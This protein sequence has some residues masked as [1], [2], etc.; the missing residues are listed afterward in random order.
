MRNDSV[1]PRALALVPSVGQAVASP[2]GRQIAMVVECDARAAIHLVSL[3]GAPPRV[4][5]ADVS[6]T[7]ARVWGPRD[8][9]WSPDGR[10]LAFVASVDGRQDVWTI[11]VT[12]GSLRQITNY[13]WPDRTPR[14][15]PDG[16]SLAIVTEIDGRDSI[17]VVDAD[18]GWPRRLTDPAFHSADHAWSPDGRTLAF[19]SNRQP[20]Q[21]SHN[22]D[23]WAVDL[24][25]GDERRLTEPDG[26]AD[27]EPRWSPD[28]RR[29][30][31]VSERTGWKQVWTMAADGSDARP[32]APETA[33]QTGP[34]WS[35]DGRRLAWV[36]GVGVTAR[37][38]VV[39]ADDGQ[40]VAVAPSAHGGTVADLSW[41]GE[42]E[43]LCTV[44]SSP[45]TA[46]EV[47]VRPI[48]GEVPTRL[49][50]VVPAAVAALD[51]IE[52][53]TVWVR[54]GDGL[55]IES[56]LFVPRGVRP[57]EERP[58]LV[59]VHG[60]PTWQVM[61]GWLPEVQ[62]LVSHGYTVIAPNFRG[63]TGYGRDFDRANDDDWGG[64]DLDDCVAA[65][66]EL[67][68]LP[69][70]ASDRIGI[71][72]GSYGG[73][74]TLLALG[75]RPDAFQVGID[76]YGSSDEATLWLQTDA[77]G[78]RGIE[79][80]IGSPLLRRSG[81]QAG[82]PLRYAD[83]IRAPLLMLHGEDDQRVTLQQSEAMRTELD[84]LGKCYEYH[85][86]PD[87]PHGFKRVDNWVDSQ[88]RI[89]D[90]LGRYL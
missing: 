77:P 16:R 76:L 86:Y 61:R 68:R 20:D 33:E 43:A 11:D 70:I 31:F 69:W 17:G 13:N 1:S 90:F 71:W 67:R 52:P 34:V 32:V 35:P 6:P 84:R 26:N 24:Q 63:S 19:V 87:E 8:L 66:D 48:D 41:F 82:A 64:G 85:R 89:V 54:G 56:L 55:Q 46:G 28:G 15:S 22:L 10:H 9:D 57:G 30:V 58:A 12:T 4:L 44:E 75:K 47:W 49:T 2:T 79:Q 53:S 88:E 51:L 59:Y 3:D 14:W 23:L 25:S 72:G 5:T 37:L 29:L 18:G 74:L 27:T 62:H 39:A 81:F 73:Y 80:E 78:R 42:G 50:A 65:A 60:G 83:R 36:R 40:T 38:T 21:A 7:G 45:V